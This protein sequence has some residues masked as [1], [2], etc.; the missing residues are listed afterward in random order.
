MS[1]RVKITPT[2]FKIS[3]PGYDVAT[4]NADQL[5]FNALTV[6]YSGVHVSGVV[7]YDSSWPRGS[8]GSGGYVSYVP[9]RIY[10]EV[11]F[12]RTFSQPPLCLYAIKPIGSTTVAARNRYANGYFSG[13]EFFS[14][15]MGVCTFTDRIRF[16]IDTYR[17]PTIP[18]WVASPPN[19]LNYSFAYA[20]FYL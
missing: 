9:Y 14:T 12:G 6:G 3:R 7:N 11:M 16:Y 15:V 8:V 20:V 1:T 2:D 18:V 4:A 5:A 17:D 19:G 10:K 13:S